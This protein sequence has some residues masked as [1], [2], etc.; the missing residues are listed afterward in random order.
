VRLYKTCAHRED[1]QLL[2]LLSLL[3]KNGFKF[4][5]EFPSELCDSGMIYG[6][7]FAD[8]FCLKVLI[9][10]RLHSGWIK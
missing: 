10:L 6:S 9:F 7:N 2:F 1:G 4:I 5:P 3:S 8:I